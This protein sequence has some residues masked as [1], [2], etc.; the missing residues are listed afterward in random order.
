[1]VSS[2]IRIP[3]SS[4]SPG[5]HDLRTTTTGKFGGYR[6]RDWYRRRLIKVISPIDEMPAARAASRG[7]SDHYGGWRTTRD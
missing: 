3:P 1:M 5:V 6:H 7:R 4:M 2:L